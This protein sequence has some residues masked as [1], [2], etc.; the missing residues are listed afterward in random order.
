MDTPPPAPAPTINMT[1]PINMNVSFPDGASVTLYVPNVPGD[2]KA[3]AKARLQAVID[4][5]D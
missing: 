3:E 4:T 1:Q 5:L 2:Q